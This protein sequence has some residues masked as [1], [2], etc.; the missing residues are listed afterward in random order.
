MMQ[1]RPLMGAVTLL[2]VVLGMA[3]AQA[4]EIPFDYT[5]CASGTSIVVSTSKELT[6]SSYQGKRI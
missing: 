4:K 5:Y 1:G 2:G 3:V 6:V